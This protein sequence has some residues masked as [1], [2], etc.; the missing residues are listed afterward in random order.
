MNEIGRNLKRVRL[1]KNLSLKE[2]GKFLNMS[3]T[4]VAKYAKGEIVPDS[5]KLIEFAKAYN[6]RT[7]E[8]LKSYNAPR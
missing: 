2:S 4:A 5:Q 7:I 6:V 3:T 1:L 8:L